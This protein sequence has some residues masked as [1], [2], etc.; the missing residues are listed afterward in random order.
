MLKHMSEALTSIY[1][2]STSIIFVKIFPRVSRKVI[3]ARYQNTHSLIIN[4]L[5]MMWSWAWVR[6]LLF[7]VSHT[8]QK[9]R[10][11]IAMV[12]LKLMLYNYNDRISNVGE[13]EFKFFK[14]VKRKILIEN[15]EI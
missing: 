11:V 12:F 1:S 15:K 8:H 14:T 2:L 13:K 4:H 7:T 6:N 9:S 5:D 10:G 3:F